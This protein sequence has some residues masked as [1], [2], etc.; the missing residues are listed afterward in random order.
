MAGKSIEVLRA[1][2]AAAI[3][4]GTHEEFVAAKTALVEAVTGRKLSA[5]EIAYI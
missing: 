3:A 4:N 5:G 2:C 1:G